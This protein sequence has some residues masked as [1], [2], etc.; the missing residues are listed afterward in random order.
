MPPAVSAYRADLHARTQG[1]LYSGWGHFAFTSLASLGVIALAITR[2]HD[3]RPMEWLVLPLGFL[4]ANGAEYFG[5][6]GPM[7]RLKRGLGLIYKRHAGQHHRFFTHEAMEYGS[8]ADFKAVL[9]PPVLLFFFLG[10]IATP[11]AVVLFLATTANVGWLFVAV[12]MGYFLTYEWLHFCYHLP[13]RTWLGGHALL[14]RL[15]QHH[16]THHDPAL[17]SRYN[18]NITFP[19]F[20]WLMGT[21][22][23][24]GRAEEGANEGAAERARP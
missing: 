6:R 17:M 23:R 24:A 1:S 22:Y 18:F 11:M 9:F 3:V 10:V 16:R 5:H 4:V 21:S 8:P 14:R 19:V 7:H 12:S 20:D 13:E 2:V 15:R